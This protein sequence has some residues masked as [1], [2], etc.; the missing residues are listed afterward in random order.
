MFSLF[1]FTKSWNSSN[2]SF[3]LYS[4]HPF[5]KKLITVTNKV[6]VIAEQCVKS[7]D[8]VKNWLVPRTVAANGCDLLTVINFLMKEC[9]GYRWNGLLEEFQLFVK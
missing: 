9:V 6:I 5:V 4:T 8:E 3:H 2:S 1:H 7:N